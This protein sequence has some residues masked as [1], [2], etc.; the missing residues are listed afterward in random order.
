M[1]AI[2]SEHE[3]GVACSA[4]RYDGSLEGGGAGLAGVRNESTQARTLN[5]FFPIAP[6]SQLGGIGSSGAM[7]DAASDCGQRARALKAQ[8]RRR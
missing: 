7:G 1:G 6:A 5:V 8:W 2:P 4:L 3:G